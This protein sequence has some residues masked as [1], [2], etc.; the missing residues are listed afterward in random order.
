MDLQYTVKVD[1]ATL[2][3]YV[4]PY[5][6]HTGRTQYGKRKNGQLF[7]KPA[8]LGWRDVVAL[9]VRQARADMLTFG[10]V[11]CGFEATPP[12]DKKRDEDNLKKTVYDALVEA[13]ALLDDSMIKRGFYTMHNANK[14]APFVSVTLARVL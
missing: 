1:E 9:I 2:R 8:V 6:P 13:G 10:I 4:F 7:L 11:F 5:P 12:D 14:A 3:T